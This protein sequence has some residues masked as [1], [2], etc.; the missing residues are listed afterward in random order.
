MLTR[1]GRFSS[2]ALAVL[3]LASC[4]WSPRPETPTPPPVADMTLPE[5]VEG[6]TPVPGKPGVPPP[7]APVPVAWSEVEGWHKDDPRQVLDALERSCRVLRRRSEWQQVCSDVID[8][9]GRPEPLVRAFF[10]RRF[11]PYQLLRSVGNPVG[12]VTGYYI[13]DLHGSR[14]PSPDYPYP[15]YRLPDDLLVI[16][17]GDV[18]PELRGYRR[19]GRLEEQ[20]V[21][22]YWDRAA[23][24]GDHR[25]LAGKELLWVRDPVELFFLHIQGS[26]R[27]LFEDGSWTMVGYSGQNGYPY[28]SISSWLVERGIM[29]L[30]KM[31]MQNIKAWAR[32]NPSQVGDL[33]NTNPSYIFFRELPRGTVG[34]PGALGVPL[35]PERSVAVDPAHVPLGTPVFLSTTWPNSDRPLYRLMAAQDTGG[36]I[37]GPVRADFFW[38]MGDDAGIEAGRMKQPLKMWMLLPKEEPEPV[39]QAEST[40]LGTMGSGTGTAQEV[41]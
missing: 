16:D 5:T 4:S 38:G 17:L 33:L 15:L 6:L 37:K 29:P 25:P 11:T 27:I 22:P 14:Q 18:Y 2:T 31:S 23:I 12:L 35:T 34:P 8:F 36:A 1:I 32:D 30:E 9:D 41:D 40:M 20:R 26:G 19:R 3:L 13:P 10:E 21:L 39:P 7:P 28:R 24:E